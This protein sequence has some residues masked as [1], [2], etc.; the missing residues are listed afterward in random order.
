VLAA[1]LVGMALSACSRDP[2]RYDDT[3]NLFGTRLSSNDVGP[4]TRTGGAVETQPLAAPAQN[5]A[6]GSQPAYASAPPPYSTPNAAPAPAPNYS[7]QYASYGHPTG[8]TQAPYPSPYSAPASVP[9]PARFVHVVNHGETL[10]S[11]SRRY[12]VSDSTII[13]AND[14]S[15]RPKLRVGQRLVIPGAAAATRTAG[16]NQPPRTYE[17]RVDATA[18]A[19]TSPADESP[20]RVASVKPIEQ[21]EPEPALGGAP[22]FRWPVK[23]RIISGFGKKPNGQHNDGINLS[24]PEGTEVKAAESGVVAYS[25]NELKGYGNLVLIRHS[26]GWVTAYAH[27]SEIL[28]KR[29]D[30]VRRGQAIARAGQTGGVGL[31]QLHFEIRKGSTPVDPGLHL[32]SL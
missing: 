16:G 4:A 32:S 3:P 8:G 17:R 31:P 14:L 10:S 22:Q 27:N 7:P 18:P 12:G 26:D 9:A 6:N 29:G 21:A 1:G 24:V 2:G 13:R 19:A 5:Y 20:E 11:I 15:S 23:G 30:N 28:V 25:G